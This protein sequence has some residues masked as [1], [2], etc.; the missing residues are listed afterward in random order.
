M[1]TWAVVLAGGRGTRFWPRSRRN[2]PKQ[3]LAIGASRTLVQQTVDRIA[4]LA[5]ADRVL[6]VT[7][8]DMV[9]AI[10]AQL[11][12]VPAAN[13]LVEPRGR[14]TAPAIG[15]AAVEVEKRGGDA[16]IV[17]PSDHR[18]A[19]PAGFAA[20]ALAC[21]AAARASGAIVLLGQTPDRP[22]TGYGYVEMGEAS[23]IAGFRRVARFLEKPDRATAER[24]IAERPVL[25]NG[26]MFAFTTAALKAA[27]ARHLP[28]TAA[29]LDQIRDGAPVEAAWDATDAISIDYGVLEREPDL[30]VIPCAF[31]WSDLGSW[32]ALDDVL[33]AAPFGVSNADHAVGI[34][35]SGCI[36]DAPGRL[37]A[38]IGV[39]DLVIV[40]TGDVVLVA[41]KSRADEVAQVI[42]EL[43]R[44]GLGSYT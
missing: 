16:L 23:S 8:P 31:G 39:R 11:P 40:D 13:V 25:W 6:V 26:G 28:R 15:W 33:P 21:D 2:L 41:A 37:V 1:P 36:A 19:D 43:E 7:G 14:N 30:L 20:T 35:A 17:L 42:A 5:P 32:T 3:C 12:E 27:F 9:D 10:R 18:I 34:G 44:R 4:P 22:H 24:L 38:A 29:A